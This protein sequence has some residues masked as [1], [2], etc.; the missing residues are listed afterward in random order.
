MQFKQNYDKLSI[1]RNTLFEKT[2]FVYKLLEDKKTSSI[3]TFFDELIPKLKLVN[4]SYL[5]YNK[6]CSS[7]YCQKLANDPNMKEVI[8]EDVFYEIF[9]KVNLHYKDLEHISLGSIFYILCLDI[10]NGFRH[11]NNNLLDEAPNAETL[12]ANIFS[13][14]EKKIL[15]VENER[16][17]SAEKT[18]GENSSMESH[19][20]DRDHNKEKA[21]FKI[22][23]M[24][25]VSPAKLIKIPEKN[26]IKEEFEEDLPHHLIIDEKDEILKSCMDNALDNFLIFEREKELNGYR[27]FPG[28]NRYLMPTIPAKEDNYRKLK[29]TEIYPFLN[30]GIALYEKYEIIKK[31][32]EVFKSFIPEQ[33]SFDFSDRTYNEVMNRDL[34]S[35]VLANAM[36]YD[37]ESLSHYNERDDNLLFATYYR[38][39]RGRV[40]WKRWNYRYLSRPDFDNWIKVFESNDNLDLTK[41]DPDKPKSANFRK[42]PNSGKEQLPSNI[43]VETGGDHPVDESDK[44]KEF[45][46]LIAD[47]NILYRGDDTK[48]GIISETVKYMFPSDNGIF[49]NKYL[50]YGVFNS[51]TSYCIKDNL[52][53]GIRNNQ[54]DNMTEFWLKFDNDLYLTMNYLGD[55]NDSKINNDCKN[56][57]I[58][59]INIGNG[60]FIQIQPNGDIC[61]KNFK[62]QSNTSTSDQPIEIQRIISSKASVVRHFNTGN[63]QIMY[64][65]A[66]VCNISNGVA[67]NTNNKGYRVAKDLSHNIE[68]EMERI[69]ITI[70]SDPEYNSKIYIIELT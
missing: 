58:T 21:P 64:A 16:L 15:N 27:N 49:I 50:R 31:Y 10:N 23:P 12:L 8:T 24:G 26:E 36:M 4:K 59:S 13:D 51:F 7:T 6:W 48:I 34:L 2:E 22:E 19:E 17:N 70:Q 38:C 66:N 47:E 69:P 53:L 39:P 42:S 28:I 62:M 20:R 57:M 18:D 45:V 56:G 46:N 29:K 11:S 54:N 43:N 37:C 30:V 65:N 3:D 60:L 1:I 40:Y 68:Y 32:E 41:V 55:Y 61:Q 25:L 67:I 52:R 63:I 9:D 44:D 35:Q 33:N 14:I 5:L